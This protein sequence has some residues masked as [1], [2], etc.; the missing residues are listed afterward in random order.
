MAGARRVAIGA[1][2]AAL[3]AMLPAGAAGQ[4]GPP[5]RLEAVVQYIAG[6]TVYVPLGTADGLALGD[7]LRVV[8]PE[9]GRRLGLLVVAGVSERRASLTFAGAPFPITRGARLL[10]DPATGAAGRPAGEPAAAAEPAAEAAAAA[11]SPTRE[12]ARPSARSAPGP[13]PRLHGTL[14]VDVDAYRATSRWGGPGVPS[15]RRTLTTPAA[16][17]RAVATGLPLGLEARTNVRAVYRASAGDLYGPS[18]ILRVYEATVERSFRALPLQLQAGRFWDP[19]SSG[20]SFWDGGMVRVGGAGFG[21]GAVA[22]YEPARGDEGFST[23]LEK[24]SAFA[25]LKHR[26]GRFSY[27]G[28]LSFLSER[29]T[30]V[31]WRRTVVGWAQRARWGGFF[32]SQRLELDPD[33]AE[34][35]DALT[36][37]YLDVA[38]PLAGGL[39]LD[40][41]YARDLLTSRAPPALPPDPVPGPA[42]AAERWRAGASW[43]GAFA[44][45]SGHAGR[46]RY[47]D[48]PVATVADGSLYIP[49]RDGARPGIGLVASLW[50]DGDLRS[51]FLSPSLDRSFGALDVRAAYQLYDT[52]GV[53]EQRL[54]GGELALGLP[55][56][57]GLRARISAQGQWGREM[58][59]LRAYSSLSVQF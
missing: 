52:A 6:S 39:R 36:R 4:E 38:V 49:S 14:G 41:S 15:T 20:R 18:G 7:T 24:W 51:L 44:S 28:D 16:R 3:I 42:L 55:F 5:G 30:E 53:D 35:A 27:S 57:S 1:V 50:D 23:A 25:D 32:F 47:G 48:H 43:S 59:T 22:G 17:L 26:S 33:P 56:R 9:D 29:S 21:V 58:T 13:G 31:D 37:A 8:R 46:I 54:H 11:A 19:L 2:C 45:L 10:L 34:G 12:L 40:G